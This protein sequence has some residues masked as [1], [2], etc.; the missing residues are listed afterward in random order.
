M[1]SNE[2]LR[3]MARIGALQ[4]AKRIV[5]EFPDILPE[6]NALAKNPFAAN[7]H[8]RRLSVH[9]DES[10]D[11]APQRKRRKL[12]AAARARIGAAQRKRWRKLRREA[13]GDR[14]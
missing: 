13:A 1:F 2:E 5:S 7:G 14:T 3:S 11:P 10:S 4:Q 12:S 9:V 8:R 6:L